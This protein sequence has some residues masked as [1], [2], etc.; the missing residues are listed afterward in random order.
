MYHSP[1]LFAVKIF[2]CFLSL[3]SSCKTFPV[4]QFHSHDKQQTILWHL[5]NNKD[6]TEIC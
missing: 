2:P 4:K 1:F 5:V 6:I 3:I